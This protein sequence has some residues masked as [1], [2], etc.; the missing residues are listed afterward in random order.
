MINKKRFA[1]LLAVVLTMCLLPANTFAYQTTHTPIVQDKQPVDILVSADDSYT[2]SVSDFKSNLSKQLTS[3]GLTSDQVRIN[4]VQTNIS[5]ANFDDWYVYDHY[6]NPSY[7]TSGAITDG[8]ND[9]SGKHPYYYYKEVRSSIPKKILNAAEIALHDKLWADYSFLIYS[10]G[11][12]VEELYPAAAAQVPYS[13]LS[14]SA[15]ATA[16]SA[17]LAIIQDEVAGDEYE[18]TYASLTDAQ[19]AAIADDISTAYTNDFA[20]YYPQVAFESMNTNSQQALARTYLLASDVKDYY[21]DNVAGATSDAYN[22]L[23]DNA[24][25]AYLNAYR[26]QWED[27]VFSDYL[28]N[29]ESFASITDQ[30]ANKIISDYY[31]N[32]YVYEQKSS[33]YEDLYSYA[34]THYS[35]QD[36][37]V[38][39]IT[40]DGTY[41]A[42]YDRDKHIYT[43]IDS[44]NNASM[45]FM[46]YSHP[47]YNDFLI[48]PATGTG[49]KTVNFDIDASKVNTHS[50]KGAGFLV[51]SGI[52]ASGYIHGYILF[53]AFKNG[54]GSAQKYGTVYLLKIKDDVLASDLHNAIDPAFPDES[55]TTSILDDIYTT[56]ITSQSFTIDTDSNKK[57]IRIS[58]TPTTFS[59]TDSDYTSS[60]AIGTTNELFKNAADYNT[61]AGAVSLESTGY[62]G[63]GPIVAYGS[64]TCSKLTSFTFSNLQMAL[65]STSVQGLRDANYIS[66]AKKFYV[67][68]TGTP[69]PSSYEDPSPYYELL[70]RMNKD[71]IYYMST[72]GNNIVTANGGNG[73]YLPS[74]ANAAIDAATYIKDVETGTKGWKAFATPTESSLLPVA[75]FDL[76]NSSHQISEI[77]QKHMTEAVTVRFGNIDKSFSLSPSAGELTYAYR[78]LDPSGA[79]IT[80]GNALTITDASPAGSYTF[81]LT[82]TDNVGSSS[83]LTHTLKVF[84]D[85]TAP[86]VTRSGSTTPYT[87]GTLDVTLT[88]AGSGVAAYAIGKSVSGGAI[89]YGDEVVLADPVSSKSLTLSLD[90]GEYTLYIKTFDA[91]GNE[92]VWSLAVNYAGE[93]SSGSSGH[94]VKTDTGSV[95]VIV[96]GQTQNAGISKSTVV[97]GKTVTTVTVD[98][99][100]LETLLTSGGN[101]STVVIPISGNADQAIGGLTGAMIKSMESKEA[102]LAVKTDSVTYTLP[103]KEINIDAIS[104]EL[105]TSLDLS[106]IN[107]QISIAKPSDDTVKV[108]ANAAETGGFTIAVPAVDFTISCTYAGKSVDV[109]HFNDFVERTVAIP[110]GVD[111][112]KITTGIVVN[113]DGTTRQVPTKITQIDGKYYAVINS[114][115][116]STYAIIW[117]PLEF[118]DVAS[119]WAKIAVNDMG[120]RMIVTG[121][122]DS[123]YA[124]DRDITRAEFAAI[125]V[126]ALGLAPGTGKTA[127]ADV[128]SSAW[129]AGYIQTAADYGIIS[130]YSN[131]AFGPSNKITREQAM[132]M[133]A[134]ATKIT[135]LDVTAA[136]SSVASILASYTDKSSISGLRINK[137][138]RMCQ[139]RSRLRKERVFYRS[140]R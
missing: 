21:I 72:G 122:G 81:G 131:S 66:D 56:Q 132:A 87:S 88:D 26:D 101:G 96:N 3:L 103:A 98:S 121:I 123:K 97:D 129:Y 44:S 18:A 76:M 105:G 25:A 64:H 37:F 71:N 54:E 93:T 115:T 130:G 79:L 83:E 23:D 111:P 58:V 65:K 30:R 43:N 15:A 102:T 140:E 57:N 134:R 13:S 14:E 47:S 59:C 73:L 49:T 45:T 95:N 91:C 32:D 63:F 2:G 85:S 99:A 40:D 11:T 68:L 70:G 100:K 116:N 52:D 31:Y 133:I 136:D 104:K 75:A 7:P 41:D 35:A 50:L 39:N 112:S 67:V 16:N 127:F 77:D 137:Y 80:T 4:T 34:L 51:N 62:G 24:K 117:H 125:V 86:T 92:G 48:Y 1:K 10:C 61:T 60:G 82:A 110:D 28:E 108:V 20:E 19:K 109:S 46:G 78:I 94:K 74:P 135:G 22:A 118:T 69:E 6:Y 27:D 29:G 12:D 107:V 124:P 126:R 5:L 36:F 138:R 128:A 8:W 139:N 84:N 53:Y 55:G 33:A 120:S 9:Y 113:A 17:V 106:N 114:L 90:S 38:T 89:T 42:I 119:H